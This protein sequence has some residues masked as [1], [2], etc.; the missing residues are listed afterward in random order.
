MQMLP[1][2]ANKQAGRFVFP[3]LAVLSAVGIFVSSAMTGEVSG[4]ASLRIAAI[5][6]Y[7]SPVS[8]NTLGFLNFLVRK[9]AHF[10]VYFVLAFFIAQSLK[11]HIHRLRYLLLSAWAI[12]SVYGITDEI[13]QHFVPGRVMT[14]SD[15]LINSAGAL[16]GAA[17]VCVFCK[18]PK[19]P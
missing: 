14:I 10:V 15:M 13:H 6:R 1:M 8:D 7:I 2:R 19:S 3:L 16:F 12:A 9:A 18:L 5:V 4:N 17:L 11:Y